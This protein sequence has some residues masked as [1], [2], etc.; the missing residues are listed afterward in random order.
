MTSR[1]SPSSARIRGDDYQH[2][3]AWIQ[4]VKAICGVD[5]IT[6]IGIEDPKAANADDITVYMKNGERQYY[7]VKY[8]VDA[9]ETIGIQWLMTTKPGRQSMLQRFY[10]LWSGEPDERKPKIVLVTNKPIVDS[11]DLLVSRDGSDG[12]IARALQNKHSQSGIDRIRCNIAKHL[13]I[14]EEDVVSFFKD[15]NFQI[16][17]PDVD[18][19]GIAKEHMCAAGLY[20]DEDAVNKGVAIVRDW[21]K[22]GKR[23]IF[24]SEMQKVVESL[25]QSDES[26]TAS[27]LIQMIDHTPS[28]ESDAIV[29]DWV[30]LFPGDKPGVRHWPQDSALWNNKFLPDLW[31]AAEKLRQQGHTH[32]R[33]RGEMRL[34]T[35]FAVGSQ[36]RKTARFVVSSSQNGDVWSS[37]G[38]VTQPAFTCDTTILGSGKDFAVGMSLSFD[39]SID[40]LE[41]L[42]DQ[43]INVG[44]YFHISATKGINNQSVGDA[45]E[46]RGWAYQI[47]DSIRHLVQENRPDKIHLFLAAPAGMV[48]L[49]GHLWD[50]MPYTQV[51]EYL[52]PSK[53]Y[54]PSYVISG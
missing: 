36:M 44:K 3:L 14:S 11:R 17:I 8:S 39:L 9:R 5:K 34:P 18:W 51:Y 7:Q 26:Y 46:A 6:K 30:D 52:G 32:I 10:S 54:A 50:Q 45:T 35:W 21:V 47:R 41:C 29:F 13:K 53:R 15:I 4:V 27:I 49:L 25:K 48:L 20:Y 16:G 24:L 1:L 23:E 43:Q 12:T 33:V 37:I 2:L 28:Q 19:R 40:V 42:R 38:Q 31:K 22:Q